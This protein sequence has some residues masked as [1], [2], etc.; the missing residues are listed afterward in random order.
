MIMKAVLTSSA[1]PEYGEVT[2]PFPIPG[3]EYDHTME[4]LESLEIGDALRQN[5]RIVEMDSRFSVLRQLEQTDAAVDE[6]DYLAKRLDSFNQKEAAQFQGMAA[7]WNLSDIQDFINLTFCCQQATVITDFSNLEQVGRDHCLDISGGMMTVEEYNALDGRA[8]AL[9]RIHS[10][11]GTV[12]PY[13][14]AYDNGMKLEQIYR[15][16]AFPA[17]FYGDHPL[18]LEAVPKEEGEVGYLYLPATTRQIGRTLLRIGAGNLN[19]VR[20]RVESDELPPE[21]SA[22]LRLEREGLDDLNAMCH[23]IRQLEPWRRDM[24]EA[25]VCLAQPDCASEVRRLAEELDQFTFVPDVYTPEE[26]GRYM[27]QESGRFEYDENLAG[28]YDYWNYGEQR[29]QQEGGRF[30]ERGYV[31]YHGTVPLEELMRGDPS[32]RQQEPGMQMGGMAW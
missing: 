17:Y 19:D 25:V 15:G 14:V 21:I 12:T 10:E 28:F 30:T 24:L 26:Y 3:G 22:R 4:L 20:L 2:I 5:C 11:Q 23:A 1:H 8:E 13:G 9:K 27:I 7:K 31:S 29:I 16:G 6:L 18:V 32:G